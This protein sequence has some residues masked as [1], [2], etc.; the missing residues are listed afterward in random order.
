MKQTQENE[1]REPG[2][3]ESP[4]HG[5]ES[6][7]NPAAGDAAETAVEFEVAAPKEEAADSGPAETDS[8]GSENAPEEESG[9]QALKQLEA[10]REQYLRLMAE[11]DNYKRRMAREYDRIV[12]QANER[13]MTDIIDVR[14]SM[15][16]A[17][18]ASRESMDYGALCE[19]MKLIATKLDTVLGRHGLTSF[20]AVGDSFDPELH[21]ALMKVCDTAVGTDHIVQVYEKGYRLHSRVIKHARVVV[22]SGPPP[23]GGCGEPTFEPDG[24][25]KNIEE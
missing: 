5:A 4:G 24:T 14:E 20:T 9:E 22:S 16:R 18:A 25:G 10:Q 21:D 1:N 2:T 7:G 23:E 6:N 15:E 8:G 11:F 13:L 17:L 3:G 12:E 19:G